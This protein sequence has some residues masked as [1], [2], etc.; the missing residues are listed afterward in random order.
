MLPRL[1]RSSKLAAKAGRVLVDQL[2]RVDQ[3]GTD[4]E[5]AAM[6]AAL[7]EKYHPRSESE[8]KPSAHA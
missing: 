8:S 5:V 7:V 6:W 2:D 1:E 4:V 3:A